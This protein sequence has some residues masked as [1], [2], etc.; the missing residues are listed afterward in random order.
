MK[1]LLLI[2]LFSLSSY[3]TLFRPVSFEEQ[4]K[5]ADGFITGK[6]KSIEYLEG[7]EFKILTKVRIGESDIFIPGGKYK[8]TIVKVHG[9]PEFHIGSRVGVFVKKN[10]DRLWLM[11]L[12]LG[13][14]D[15]I[16]VN[17]KY[18]YR[19]RAYP[20]QMEVSKR[21]IESVQTFSEKD[22]KKER[23]I[24]AVDDEPTPKWPSYLFYLVLFFLVLL[25]WDKLKGEDKE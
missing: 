13:T 12:S 20:E 22:K 25:P 16:E 3:A 9:A 23:V 19:N 4:Q 10:Q 18:F 8:N 11:N 17:D 2:F 1:Y 14:F 21:K 5:E 7:R 6:V 24:A 15:E